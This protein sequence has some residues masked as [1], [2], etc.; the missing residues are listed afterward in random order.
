MSSFILVPL[1]PRNF[2]V[3]HSNASQQ[4]SLSWEVPSI[5]NGQMLLYQYCYIKVSNEICNYTTDNSTK[6]VNIP[7]LG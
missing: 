2:K 1:M 3:S 7:N 5:T 4:L 6:S